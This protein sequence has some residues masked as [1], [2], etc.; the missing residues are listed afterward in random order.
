MNI[1]RWLIINKCGTVRTTKGKPGLDWD[2]IAIMLDINLPDALFSR[3]RLEAKIFIPE[4]AALKEPI[5]A[6]VIDNVQEAIQTATGLTFSINVI[7][8]EQEDD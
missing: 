1:E 5:T 2:E 8:E 3:P 4:E 7:K 6:G